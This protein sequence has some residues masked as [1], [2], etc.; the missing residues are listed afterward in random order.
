[1]CLFVFVC[2]YRLLRLSGF[3]KGAE[4]REVLRF[5]KRESVRKSGVAKY[6]FVL[7]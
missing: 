2:V 7:E 6:Q 1:M 5:L 3:I 4:R